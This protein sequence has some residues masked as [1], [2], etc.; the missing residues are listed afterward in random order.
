MK[1]SNLRIIAVSALMLFAFACGGTKS[2]DDGEKTTPKLPVNKTVTKVDSDKKPAPLPPEITTLPSGLS[3]N[4]FESRLKEIY[5]AHN[6]SDILEYLKIDSKAPVYSFVKD[7]ISMANTMLESSVALSTIVKPFSYGMHVT[8]R[9]IIRDVARDEKNINS[10]VYL[11]KMKGGKRI[12]HFNVGGASTI[13]KKLTEGH[14]GKF[15]S[16]EWGGII[17]NKG[18]LNEK[19]LSNVYVLKDGNSFFISDDAFLLNPSNQYLKSLDS[20]YTGKTNIAF[21]NYR[22]QNRIF[23]SLLREFTGSRQARVIMKRFRNFFDDMKFYMAALRTSSKTASISW[24]IG[25]NKKLR[26]SFSMNMLKQKDVKGMG[27]FIDSSSFGFMTDISNYLY[28]IELSRY[29][30]KQLENLGNVPMKPNDKA[31]YKEIMKIYKNS[32]NIL[33]SIKGG[34]FAQIRKYKKGYMI[35]S[36]MEIKPNK[37]NT[38]LQNS[39]AI[40]D[41]VNPSRWLKYLPKN[42]YREIS[43]LKDVVSIKTRNTKISGKKGL[44]ITF[45]LRWNKIP[46]ALTGNKSVQKNL[47]K[48]FGK[49]IVI[50]LFHNDTHVFAMIGNDWKK[51]SRAL[52]AAKGSFP[53]AF[54]FDSKIYNHISGLD[55]AVTLMEVF[56]HMKD[57]G[58]LPSGIEKRPEGIETLKILKALYSRAWIFGDIYVPA[59]KR[60]VVFSSDYPKDSVNLIYLF[61][62]LGFMHQQGQIALP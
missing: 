5:V 59:G 38:V 35:S 48:F 54:V 1:I 29:Y 28:F 23:F 62:K 22:K 18:N 58:A 61:G 44:E 42:D 55:M 49:K 3:L 53:K 26:S 12:I 31:I 46:L 34:S 50:R 47:Q 27:K 45:N 6:V 14:Y 7:V 4:Q 40:F 39:K 57:M 56:T 25:F 36:G 24:E 43:W 37:G 32:V 17:N 9:S 2:K 8:L 15:M 51:Q 30:G 52:L 21:L 60:S 33:E 11:V 20:D 19:N 13:N 16:R 10:G 41:S